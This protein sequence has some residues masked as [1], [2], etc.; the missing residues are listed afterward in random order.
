[1][2]VNDIFRHYKGKEYRIHGLSYNADGKQLVPYVEFS[3]LETGMRFS[4]N[5]SVFLEVIDRPDIKYHGP[6]FVFVRKG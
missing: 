4:K 6:R 3:D 2:Q 1:M 5:L